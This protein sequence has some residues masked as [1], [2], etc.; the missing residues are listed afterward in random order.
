MAS[1]GSSSDYLCQQ[2]VTDFGST[3]FTLEE[4]YRST[5]AIIRAANKLKPNSQ[6][7]HEFALDGGLII[8]SFPDENAEAKWVISTIKYLLE[9]Q[10]HKEIE[11]E[12]SLDKIVIIARNR[13]IFAKLDEELKREGIDFSLRK[14]ERA[15]EL[16]SLF[17][18]VLDYGLR[19]K[20]NP[21]GWVDGVKL[22]KLLSVTPPSTWMDNGILEK[23]SEQVLSTSIPFPEI[24]SYLLQSINDLDS[25]SPNIRKFFKSLD[26]KLSS[27]SG[28]A[29]D[30]TL[31]L[32]LE[33]SM[34]ELRG[35]YE[36]WTRFK[37][38][39]LG[40]SLSAF[41]N[42]SAL[43]QLSLDASKTG[44]TLSTVHTMKG[45]EKDIV[46]LIGMCEGV[47][48]DYRANNPKKIEE[49][50]NTAFV[51]VTRARR[52]LYISYPE[53]RMMPWGSAK[54]QTKSRFVKELED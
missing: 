43:G 3:Q 34:K 50:R 37:K 11:G 27:L 48:P 38:K 47:F 28:T 31:K 7:E 29:M 15:E 26:D 16:T 32:E 22:C 51:A 40:S 4:N 10:Y 17:G 19:V 36:F 12:L 49:E 25:E 5:K 41:R 35:F 54:F 18:S 20:L 33:R 30:E 9:L 52:W 13:F 23:W 46:F 8:Q 45:L 21:K 42:A 53:Q 39:S 6:R 44:L 2:F 24:Q 14:G 1:Y